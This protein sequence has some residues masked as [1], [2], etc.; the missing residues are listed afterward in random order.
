MN[1]TAISTQRRRGVCVAWRLRIVASA[2]DPDE[3]IGVLAAPAAAAEK[4]SLH[5][6]FRWVCDCCALH[7][8]HGFL[9]AVARD[10]HQHQC[11]TAEL[12]TGSGDRVH[13]RQGSFGSN[14]PDTRYSGQRSRTVCV[15]GMRRAQST[16][17]SHPLVGY[18]D[19]N[20]PLGIYVCRGRRY[21]RI[22]GAFI[23]RLFFAL[24]NVFGS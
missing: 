13:C 22:I 15:A 9:V 7:A 4:S 8:V 5:C 24:E 14:Q 1:G 3:Y 11:R 19:W 10:H 18:V 2:E 12:Q 17:V 23:H 20:L 6:P 21:R 16:Y